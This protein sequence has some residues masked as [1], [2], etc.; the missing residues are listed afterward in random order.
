MLVSWVSICIF[1]LGRCVKLRGLP[2][3]IYIISSSKIIVFT[4]M[5]FVRLVWSWI[6]IG[7][8]RIYGMVLII[9]SMIF[10]LLRC[11]LR[12][13]ISSLGR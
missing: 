8:F 7:I 3:F 13:L 12:F 10:L 11:R 4:I 9:L 5:I 2:M 1:I 6:S